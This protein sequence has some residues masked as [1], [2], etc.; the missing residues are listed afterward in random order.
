MHPRIGC[1][2]CNFYP[3][4]YDLILRFS[5]HLDLIRGYTKFQCLDDLI[6][7]SDARMI[8]SRSNPRMIR[9]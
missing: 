3:S 1:I 5:L 7:K 8:V 4:E 2:I 6:L 9:S